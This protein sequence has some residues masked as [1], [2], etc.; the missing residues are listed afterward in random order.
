MLCYKGINRRCVCFEIAIAEIVGLV[1]ILHL[2]THVIQRDHGVLL[3]SF[4]L[5]E[6]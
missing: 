4:A 6:R 3:A 1:E 2:F 5:A